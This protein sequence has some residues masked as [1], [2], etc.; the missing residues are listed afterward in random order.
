MKVLAFSGSRADR[1]GI[2]AVVEELTYLGI[3]T[4]QYNIEYDSAWNRWD[5]VTK[6]TWSM[7]DARAAIVKFNPDLVLI[8]GDRYEILGVATAAYYMHVPIIHLSGGDITEGSQDDNTRHAITKL[9]SLHFTTNEKS[10][11]RVIQLGEQPTSVYNVGYPG[12]V[13]EVPSLDFAL[14]SIN[15][16]T[17]YK[18]YPYFLVVWHPNTTLEVYDNREV[19]QILHA[20]DNLKGLT[21][22]VGPNKD[23]GN[24]EVNSQL[25]VWAQKTGNLYCESLPREV[26]LSLLKHAK[27]LIGNSSSGFY[28]A[29]SFGTPVINIGDRQKGRFVPDNVFNVPFNVE[30]IQNCIEALDKLDISFSNVNPYGD[31]TSA[32]KIAEIISQITEPKMLLKKKWFDLKE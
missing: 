24:L 30:K 3:G 23:V 5:C 6:I 27:C 1:G 21:I 8:L 29:P 26:Y 22:I 25:K 15:A 13:T 28:E 32:R 7:I 19:N 12:I 16:F 31:G 18:T 10:R 17:K 20:L 9:S 11:E 2:E 14:N 4:K